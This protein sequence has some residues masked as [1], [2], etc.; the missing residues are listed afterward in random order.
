MKFII[1][2]ILIMSFLTILS[3]K[4]YIDYFKNTQTIKISLKD[5]Y[6]EVLCIIMTSEM[7][8]FERTPVLWNTW[9]K[10][11]DKTVF[12]CNYAKI[13][14]KI[15]LNKNNSK[16][17]ELAELPIMELNAIEKY[18]LMDEKVKEIIVKSYEK[19]SSTF[20]WFMLVD[21]DTFVFVENL[22]SFI[23]T[24][25]FTEPKTFGYKFKALIKTGYLSGGGGI[26]FTLK[27]LQQLHDNI[28]K[29]RC[30]LKGIDYGDLFIGECSRKS[31]VTI[32]DSRDKYNRER[33]HALGKLFSII[34]SRNKRIKHNFL[35]D[36]ESHYTGNFPDW[37]AEYSA[38]DLKK[39]KECCS[40]ESITFHYTL[41]EE[42]Y[43]FSKIQNPKNISELFQYYQV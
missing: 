23:S 10:K 17:Q 26:L 11:C 6:N 1:V 8:F 24:R 32:D 19:Y 34:K 22:K 40:E 38:Y 14:K 16:I 5:N 28:K 33:F 15:E 29:R 7:T 4:F 12:A 25:D 13:K 39:G 20:K 42:M 18:E 35:L 9:A 36:L 3:V 2:S 41:I 31:N 27:A 37:L 30:N 21:D 43:R